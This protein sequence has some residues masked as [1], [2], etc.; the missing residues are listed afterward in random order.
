[1]SVLAWS[2]INF[3]APLS[4]ARTALNGMNKMIAAPITWFRAPLSGL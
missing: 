4:V 2:P 1:L 3:Q